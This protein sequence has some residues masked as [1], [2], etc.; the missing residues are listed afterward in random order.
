M[1]DLIARKYVAIVGAGPAG[2]FAAERIAR[3]GHAVTVFDHMPSPARKFLM[4][5]RGGLNLTHSEPLETFLG[6][7][8]ADAEF[9]REA[10][11][12][13]PPSALI[14]W[15]NALGAE[16][17]VGS[18]GR[19]FPKAMKA[20]PLLRAWLRRLAEL[21]VEFRFRHRWI[22]FAGAR[23]L[24][25]ESAEGAHVEV[26]PDAVLFA[27]GGASWPRLGSDA[28]WVAP[29]REARIAVTDLRPANCGVAVS[30]SEHYREKF[31]G[32]PL[33][34]IAVTCGLQKRR[35]EAVITRSGLEGG[36]IYALT[37]A[38]REAL[39]RGAPATIHI[40]LKPD[41]SEAELTARLAR[42]RKGQTASNVLRKVLTLTPAAVNLMR[43]PS[44]LPAGGADLARRIKAV[45]IK[46]TGLTG[47][48]RAISTA[49][50]IPQFALTSDF[51]LAARPGLF[52]A[53]E[54]LD[55][56][57]PTGGYLLQAVFATARAAAD[58]IL[59]RLDQ[60]APLSRRE[61]GETSSQEGMKQ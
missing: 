20:S 6:R 52:V 1:N 16:T 45:E 7:Y 46:V 55:W 22:G 3:A 11:R 49:G 12:A 10:V 30:W 29:F 43:E 48:A 17:F 40:D 39:S 57:A 21:G 34:R 5:G 37:P 54:M 33:K 60:S 2:L 51:E 56:E 53:G 32:T 44:P 58:A 47:L 4:A 27:L 59:C 50:G 24:I 28:S 35:G 15:A 25:F 14:D 23:G 8:P 38:I 61:A 31:A 13:F 19:I 36:V 26:D 42:E 41:M 9:V 18:S